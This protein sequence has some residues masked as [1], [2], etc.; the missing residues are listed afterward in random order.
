MEVELERRLDESETDRIRLRTTLD[1]V[2]QRCQEHR[3]RDEASAIHISDLRTVVVQ[4]RTIVAVVAVLIGALGVVA[5]WTIRHAI[6]DALIQHGVVRIE[7][8]SQEGTSWVHGT[9]YVSLPQL[10]APQP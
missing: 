5:N 6:T 2:Q 10:P 4:I 7:R 8:V 9:G 1:V 3:E